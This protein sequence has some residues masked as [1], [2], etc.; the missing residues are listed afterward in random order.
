VDIDTWLRSL[1]LERYESAF[2]D[3]AI[4]AEVLP[5]LTEADLE[6]LGVLLGHRKRILRAIA[7]LDDVAPAAPAAPAKAEAERRQLTVMF[8]DLVGS[9]ALSTRHDPEDLRELIG[10][11]HRAVAG[12]VGRLDGFVAK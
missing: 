12:T 7:T 9:T 11:Y 2:R 8:C 6:K 10:D 5:E 1:G 3:N 4:D